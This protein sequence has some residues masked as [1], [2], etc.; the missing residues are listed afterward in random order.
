MTRLWRFWIRVACGELFG[1]IVFV[2]DIAFDVGDVYCSY[3]VQRKTY[4][5]T[6]HDEFVFSSITL[7]ICQNAS[8]K[9]PQFMG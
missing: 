1:I 9:C 2:D 7:S 8:L 3:C 6:T 4:W 5:G